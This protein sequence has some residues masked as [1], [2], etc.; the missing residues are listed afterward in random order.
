MLGDGSFVF[1]LML[2]SYWMIWW[3]VKRL[4]MYRSKREHGSCCRYLALSF[5]REQQ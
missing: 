4:L 3:G 1:S 5:E 2:V